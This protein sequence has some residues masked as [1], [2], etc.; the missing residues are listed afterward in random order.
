MAR[1][2]TTV[3][4]S[5]DTPIKTTDLSTDTAKEEV[6]EKKEITNDTL[7]ECKC[8]V[9]GNLI[10]KSS[11]NKGYSVEWN[12]FGDV[13]EIEYRELVSMRGNQRR[14]FENNWILIDDYDVLCKLGVEKFYKNVLGTENFEK[15]FSMSKND[16]LSIVPTLSSGT[17]EAIK[18]KAYEMIEDGTLDSVARIKALETALECDFEN[19]K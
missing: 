14:F 5:T 8:G 9:Y 4:Q 19:F 10:Y 11:L 16:I 6:N 3:D 13:Q 7:V 18:L 1:R 15:V 12:G 2:K 17:K